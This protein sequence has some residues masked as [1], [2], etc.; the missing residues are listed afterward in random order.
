MA[1]AM[2]ASDQQNGVA[3]A[4][5]AGGIA[6]VQ[7]QQAGSF[8][9]TPAPAT[10]APV[11]LP[12]AYTAAPVQLP[13]TQAYYTLPPQ[14]LPQ[15]TA[16]GTSLQAQFAHH[17]AQPAV[18]GQQPMPAQSYVCVSMPGSTYAGTVLPA[19]AAL[20]SARGPPAP[21]GVEAL[22]AAAAPQVDDDFGRRQGDP[23]FAAARVTSGSTA[24]V[25][26]GVS[27]KR[28]GDALLSAAN[29]PVVCLAT[30]TTPQ[31]GSSG[32]SD[33]ARKPQEESPGRQEASDAAKRQG[34][35]LPAQLPPMIPQ[36]APNRQFRNLPTPATYVLQPGMPAS[37][38]TYPGGL[39]VQHP[40]G[41]RPFTQQLAAPVAAAPVSPAPS[42]ASSSSSSSN[43]SPSPAASPALT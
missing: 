5:A 11:Y 23:L 29:A 15:Q 12:A 27:E 18:G 7:P 24:V 6:P 35:A 40:G 33:S 42:P 41:F 21:A 10:Y 8:V 39:V 3:A 37:Y 38:V 9:M 2:A 25:D 1:L 17:P 4:A 13:F 32:D 14:V 36:P 34:E 20:L 26:H 31:T 16:L 22:P 43:T 19:P 28:Q 30:A